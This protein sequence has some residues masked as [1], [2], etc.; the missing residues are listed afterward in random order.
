MKIIYLEGVKMNMEERELLSVEHIVSPYDEAETI[1][2][3][4]SLADEYLNKDSMGL[5]KVIVEVHDIKICYS[6]AI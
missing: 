1:N 2:R 3:F 4:C 5:E 6:K